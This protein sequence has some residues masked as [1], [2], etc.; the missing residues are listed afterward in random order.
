MRNTADQAGNKKTGLIALGAL[1]VVALIVGLAGLGLALAPAAP[2]RP[3]PQDREVRLVIAA[4]EPHNATQ[5]PMMEEQH[6]YFPGAIFANV[7]DR[8]ILTIV[9]M[10]E[11]RHGFEIDAL[12]VQTDATMDI[13]PGDEVTLTFT[14]N[15]AGVF[16]YECNVPYV[17]PTPPETEHTEC[18]EDHSEMMG[19]LIV[20]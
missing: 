2:Q 13:M 18:G 12:G 6:L 4:M 16:V 1:S 14:V 9:N 8:I 5:M 19:Y 10:D 17:P 7:G 20:Q 15:N 11:H 3:A